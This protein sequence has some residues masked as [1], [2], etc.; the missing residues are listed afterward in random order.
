MTQATTANQRN[1]FRM[2]AGNGEA[3]AG[4]YIGRK[5][6]PAETVDFSSKGAQLV[7]QKKVRKISVGDNVR[8]GIASGLYEAVVRRSFKNDAGQQVIGV[9]FLSLVSQELELRNSVAVGLGSGKH[10]VGVSFSAANICIFFSIIAA[11]YFG[12]KYFLV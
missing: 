4:V 2:Q 6:I 9:E 8:I 3:G 7:L 10:Q 11:A 12:W 5:I 1:S